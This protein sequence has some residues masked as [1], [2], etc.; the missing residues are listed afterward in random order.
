[1][2]KHL[3]L[4]ICLDYQTGKIYNV[5]CP[6]FQ[7][8]SLSLWKLSNCSTPVPCYS[9]AWYL[10]PWH[11]TGFLSLWDLDVMWCDV[12]TNLMTFGPGP[13]NNSIESIKITIDRKCF[14]HDICALRVE[15]LMDLMSLSCYWWED[16]SSE[17]CLG[18]D[19][20]WQSA[21]ERNYGII[22]NTVPDCTQGACECT[23]GGSLPS[24]WLVRNTNPGLWLAD[25]EL[26]QMSE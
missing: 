12:R 2:L 4:S 9:N 17:T 10:A 20:E 5:N 25:R 14:R 15:G 13:N 26:G 18:H 3:N 7:W 11:Y 19:N 8:R 22:V 21:N 16:V 24:L 6:V 23:L 1:M